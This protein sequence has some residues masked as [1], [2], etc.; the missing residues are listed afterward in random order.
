M[1]YIK[2]SYKKYSKL[3]NIVLLVISIS[4][5]L[6]II[7]STGLD[8]DLIN[9]IYDYFINHVNN[10]NQNILSN[11][12]YPIIIFVSITLLS[13]TIIGSFLPI[14][15]LSIE[16]ISIGLILGV[17]L[18]KK[19]L[20]GLL[21]GI[22]YFS[23]TKLLYILL[24]IYLI[25]NIYKFIKNITLSL[26]DKNNNRIYLLYSRIITK[27]LASLIII[28]IYNLINIYVTPK[29]INLFIFLI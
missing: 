14:L 6:G 26:K 22:I 1:Q 13:F 11:L 4:I 28:T 21:F 20:K 2:S 18:R 5:T 19:L 25:I 29:L 24:L 7:V 27:L 17:L 3:Y 15:V 10:F 9:N 23:I 16:N 8:K 12:L